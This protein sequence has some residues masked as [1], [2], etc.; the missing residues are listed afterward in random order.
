MAYKEHWLTYASRRD[1]ARRMHVRGKAVRVSAKDKLNART[2]TKGKSSSVRRDA[3]RLSR[4]KASSPGR[5][6]ETH[7]IR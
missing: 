7:L 1:D 3:K 6:K 2:P 5:V 4:G